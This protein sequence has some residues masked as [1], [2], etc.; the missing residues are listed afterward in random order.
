MRWLSTPAPFLNE[1]LIQAVALH[2][3]LPDEPNS[4]NLTVDRYNALSDATM[5]SLL[6]SLE[7][8]LDD[9]SNPEYEVEYHVRFAIR[10]E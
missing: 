6:E 5:D 3:F 9:V 4:S 1:R 2:L 8:L 7:V 10:S